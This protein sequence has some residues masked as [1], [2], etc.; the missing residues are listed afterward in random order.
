M[1]SKAQL[2]TLVETRA[3]DKEQAWIQKPEGNKGWSFVWSDPIVSD[4]RRIGGGMVG[5]SGG[6][7]ILAGNGWA[8]RSIEMPLS[9]EA[10]NALGLC[11]G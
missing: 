11:Q 6:V 1:D 4:S 3:T 5:R 2:M 8:V 10:P 9:L 7:L